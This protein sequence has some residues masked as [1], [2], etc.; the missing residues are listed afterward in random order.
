[1][2]EYHLGISKVTNRIY[3]GKLNKAGDDLMGKKDV[4]SEAIECVRDHMIAGAMEQDE[5]MVGIEWPREDGSKV[6][7]I[8]RI[9]PKGDMNDG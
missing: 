6:Q 5:K 4:T 1:M 7:L 3:A 2:A 9:V 8:L